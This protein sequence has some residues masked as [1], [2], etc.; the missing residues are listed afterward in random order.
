MPSQSV[1][2][3]VELYP[4][5][6]PPMEAPALLEK[7]S[8]FEPVLLDMVGTELQQYQY[9]IWDSEGASVGMPW[10]ALAES[11]LREKRRLGYPDQTLVR[12]GRLAS[13]IGQ[14]IVVTGD[15]V[16]V[17]INSDEVRYAAFHD[18]PGPGS[19]VPQ[20]VLV[21]ILD[22]EIEKLLGIVQTYLCE[23]TGLSAGILRVTAV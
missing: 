12:K 9:N 16:A 20:R 4:G 21:A 2:F 8:S 13:E 18:D 15:T 1:T 7:L 3:V 17:G 6:L 10:P 14:T 22:D 5:Y 19:H 23:L 11:T